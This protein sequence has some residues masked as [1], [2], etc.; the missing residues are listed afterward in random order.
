MT[1]NIEIHKALET[2]ECDGSPIKWLTL[3]KYFNIELNEATLIT[4]QAGF[5]DGLNSLAMKAIKN[6]RL[7]LCVGQPHGEP[8][9]QH[10]PFVD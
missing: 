3:V 1:G 6:T 2:M 8:I 10:G 4:A 5:I 9:R 7:M